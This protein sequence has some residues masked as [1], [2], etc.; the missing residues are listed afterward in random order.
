MSCVIKGSTKDFT[1]LNTVFENFMLPL[2]SMIR[3]YLITD[4]V[5]VE[6]ILPD[7]KKLKSL[8]HNSNWQ[9]LL[10]PNHYE[11]TTYENLQHLPASQ[12]VNAEEQFA[13]VDQAINVLLSSLPVTSRDSIK[14]LEWSI[15][16]ITDN[17]LN[18]SQSRAGGFIQAST[19]SKTSTVEFVVAD[20]GLGIAKTLDIADHKKA[21]E[22]A[23]KEGV[24]RNK[25]TNAGNGLFGSYQI[26][27]LSGEF[28]Y[29]LS[30]KASIYATSDSVKYDETKVGFYPGTLVIARINCSRENLLDE[31][32][33]FNSGSHSPSY[34]Y[35]EKN[36]END[37]GWM[38]FIMKQE[39]SSFGSRE[40][41]Q[42]VKTRITNLLKSSPDQVLVIDFTDIYFISSSFADEVFG[43]LFNELGPLGFMNRIQFKNI[44]KTVRGLIDRAIIQRANSES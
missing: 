4:N 26:A 22:E 11:E 30:G 8:F 12:F 1:H 44:D 35:I 38:D 16:E 3:T 23:V 15:N 37:Q 24:T 40:R 27:T 21:L 33:N 7:N 42:Q 5:G 9:H 14:A 10:A 19:F 43:R 28:F 39:A 25:K 32:L 20:S 6:V 36:Y 31:A 18:H 34:D 17:V 2:V 41:G 13:A 29:I